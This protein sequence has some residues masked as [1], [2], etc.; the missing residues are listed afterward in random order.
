MFEGAV[1][2]VPWPILKM[3]RWAK[4]TSYFLPPGQGDALKH[5]ELRRSGDC[6]ASGQ[7][8]QRK[9]ST[10]HPE[11]KPVRRSPLGG[12]YLIRPLG[13]QTPWALSDRGRPGEAWGGT[14]WGHLPWALSNASNPTRVPT[15][16]SQL[17]TRTGLCHRRSGSHLELSSAFK[18]EN[19]SWTIPEPCQKITLANYDEIKSM[20][21]PCSR[22]RSLCSN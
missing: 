17:Q 13:S 11:R 20:S 4:H 1:C 22:L 9:R 7:G 2:G 3:Q 18:Q 21:V 19:P 5:K 10:P 16:A 12:K 6:R 8:P 14:Q 15:S